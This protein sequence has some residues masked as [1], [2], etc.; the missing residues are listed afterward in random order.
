MSR[1]VAVLLLCL[2]LLLG[3]SVNE[4]V[5]VVDATSLGLLTTTVRYSLS[6]DQVRGLT[7]ADLRMRCATLSGVLECTASLESTAVVFSVLSYPRLD[8]RS[9]DIDEN[10][11]VADL[12]LEYTPLQFVLCDGLRAGTRSLSILYP[13][14]TTSFGSVRGIPYRT[15]FVT[16]LERRPLGISLYKNEYTLGEPIPLPRLGG[17]LCAAHVDMVEGEGTLTTY[18]C[19]NHT[20]T[21][22]AELQP[23]TH[24]L[25]LVRLEPK[26]AYVA[27]FST[28]FRAAELELALRLKDDRAALGEPINLTVTSSEELTGCSVHILD[29][30][31]VSV[32]A[33]TYAACDTVMLG[34]QP[35]WE[36]GEYV[37]RLRGFAGRVSGVASIRVVLEDTGLKDAELAL[38]KQTYEPGEDIR[39]AIDVP[40][41]TG[42]ERTVTELVDTS[43]ESIDSQEVN[44]LDG[45]VIPVTPDT[46]P[47]D[48]VVR[49]KVYD[50]EGVVAVASRAIHVT[51]WQP[52]SRRSSLC[53]RGSLA[54]EDD[55]IACIAEGDV[56][57]PTSSDVPVCLCFDEGGDPAHVCSFGQ[58]CAADGCTGGPDSPYT[59]VFEQ[60]RCRARRGIT[61]LPCIGQGE[62]CF[63]NCVC[64][65]ENNIPLS[66]CNTGDVCAPAGCEDAGIVLRLDAMTPGHAGVDELEDGI[67]VTW[68]GFLK[69]GDRFLGSMATRDINITARLGSLKSVETGFEHVSLDKGWQFWARFSG[70]LPPGHSTLFLIIRYENDTVHV[71]RRPFALHV[72]ADERG[73]NVSIDVLTPQMVSLESLRIGTAVRVLAEVRDDEAEPVTDLATED[74]TLSFGAVKA[75]SLSAQFEPASKRWRV[76]GTLE[77]KVAADK[78]TLKIDSLGRQA[79]ASSPLSVVEHLPL[80]LEMSRI[81]P[82]TGDNPLYSI[83]LGIGFNMDIHL[84][85]E[86]ADLVREEDFKVSIGERDVTSSLA[87]IMSTPSGVRLHLSRVKLCPD[88]PRPG[89]PVPVEVFVTSEGVTVRDRIY[90]TVQGNPGA[91]SD[92]A[93]VC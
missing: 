73:L 5:E 26:I 32:D 92:T 67:K 65:D 54:V 88:A 52:A 59:I 2:L 46:P 34:T 28:R 33:V 76:V 19:S 56:C 57:V 38:E 10:E 27:K 43:G 87:Y 22:P 85:L 37:V 93:S 6:P 20:L 8:V 24:T 14:H 53:P 72:P 9:L 63:G 86:G 39:P 71:V 36:P 16:R 29:R 21:L 61:T 75:R 23:G 12:L 64:L 1:R 41:A 30:H 13:S 55:S 84:D 25:T 44:G 74:F 70:D 89:D 80:T 47:G 18:R 50:D 48:Y 40:G 4:I 49:T 35:S 58:R 31:G 17:R 77:G 78:L 60:S 45:T 83:L 79:S 3:T 90:I 15:S 7:E 66:P 11:V 51:E 42:K 68:T 91:W 62:V 69:R 82:G 81:R